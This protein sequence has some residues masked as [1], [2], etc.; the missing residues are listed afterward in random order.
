MQPEVSRRRV[1]ASRARMGAGSAGVIARH[2]AKPRIERRR[3][4]P[5]WGCLA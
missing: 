2:R 3:I 5:S 4:L 1:A